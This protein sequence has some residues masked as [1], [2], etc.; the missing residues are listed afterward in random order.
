MNNS[1]VYGRTDIFKN[2]DYFWVKQKTVENIKTDVL[3]FERFYEI[4]IQNIDVIREK[5]SFMDRFII[6][7]ISKY[8]Q[9][10]N[11]D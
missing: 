2:L 5:C 3:F 6:T 4:K 10:Y 8:V 7:Y 11:R 9:N 1:L